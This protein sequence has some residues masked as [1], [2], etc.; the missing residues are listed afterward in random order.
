MAFY[1]SS[2]KVSTS[3]SPLSHNCYHR[4]YRG[5]ATS[6]LGNLISEFAL[7][8][9]TED[10]VHSRAGETTSTKRQIVLCIRCV[11]K[12]MWKRSKEKE[13]AR[14]GAGVKVEDDERTRCQGD[15]HGRKTKEGESKQQIF[16]SRFKGKIYI[17]GRHEKSERRCIDKC[18]RSRE[19]H[20]SL[21]RRSSRSRFPRR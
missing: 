1:S 11:R 4:L 9:R 2:F 16:A 5:F 10:E 12:L 14:R 7:S 6:G 21:R 17:S 15:H 19:E 20:S 3:Y 13:G 18:S 8:W